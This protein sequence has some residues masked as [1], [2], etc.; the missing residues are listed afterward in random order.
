[1]NMKAISIKI[2]ALLLGLL[3]TS[4][5]EDNKWFEIHESTAYNGVFV[6][7]IQ[8]NTIM[9]LSE[10][11]AYTFTVD[12]PGDV[13]G[14][15][16]LSV[17]WSGSTADTM[18]VL[19][20][21]EFPSTLSLTLDDL[22]EAI[23]ITYN[24]FSYGDNFIFYGTA[25]SKDGSVSVDYYDIEASNMFTN[26]M[27]HQGFQNQLYISC[28]FVAEDAV[29]TYEVVHDGWGDWSVGD[30]IAVI[31]N[32]DGS[33][34]IVEG[35]YE[36]Y[37]GYYC[38]DDKEYDVEVLVDAETGE[39]TVSKQAAWEYKWYF[40][41]CDPGAVGYTDYGT[42]Y[43]AGSGYVFSCAGI[44]TLDL[45]HSVSAGTFGTYNLALQKID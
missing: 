38:E 41:D 40:S 23:G 43:V 26:A 14:T 17:V 2:T 37:Q 5:D 13:V 34:I 12:D 22:A 33:G 3:V 36:A 21:T 31:A 1:M 39:A 32:A 4:C 27:F 11:A 8:E 28:S 44:I 18:F 10:D 9:S 16:D 24:D 42:G 19:Q 29:G 45:T 20:V 6:S 7:V 35:M 25:T 30:Q 15:Y